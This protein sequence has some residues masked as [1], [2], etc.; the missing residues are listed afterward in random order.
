VK[1]RII[2]P[3]LFIFL[4]ISIAGAT[5]NDPVQN[6]SLYQAPLWEQNYTQGMHDGYDYA[7]GYP[8]SY[9]FQP[10]GN[11]YTYME[12]NWDLIDNP[13]ELKFYVSNLKFLVT[14]PGYLQLNQSYFNSVYISS[15]TISII[16]LNIF[17]GG[18]QVGNG[19]VYV[20]NY[21]EPYLEIHINN[22]TESD[23]TGLKSYTLITEVPIFSSGGIAI[24]DAFPDSQP[25]LFRGYYTEGVFSRNFFLS[26]N[27]YFNETQTIHHFGID[28]IN[29]SYIYN[30]NESYGYLELQSSLPV[31]Q[32]N[33]YN[34]YNN[35]T[36]D[37]VTHFNVTLVETA[38]NNLQI[39][40]F[41][42]YNYGLQEYVYTF[43]DS[44]MYISSDI[45]PP[46]NPTP[47]PIPTPKPAN[48][49]LEITRQ[50]KTFNTG[51]F[52]YINYS[53][54]K[55]P[56]LLY[57]YQT[58]YGESEIE[59]WSFYN[60]QK[61]NYLL[62][63]LNPT[64]FTGNYYSIVAIY[65]NSRITYD[66]FS[67][68]IPF[69]PNQTFIPQIIFPNEYY[70]GK[71]FSVRAKTNQTSQ[72]YLHIYSENSIIP[73]YRYPFNSYE[74]TFNILISDSYSPQFFTFKIVNESDWSEL[75]STD[76]FIS[77]YNVPKIHNISA[78]KACFYPNE[79]IK[80]FGD[81]VRYEVYNS[82]GILI[83]NG[84]YHSEFEITLPTGDY[85]VKSYDSDD[86]ES[87][88]VVHVG[89]GE[90][91]VPTLSPSSQPSFNVVNLIGNK[92]FWGLFIL[93]LFGAV[94]A[95][96]GEKAFM[97]A[98][99]AAVM[100]NYLMGLFPQWTVILIAIVTIAILAMK[101]SEMIVKE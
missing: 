61:Y 75:Y 3:L 91:A 49:T 46:P 78:S 64:Q 32:V 26:T 1:T 68:G 5:I 58:D 25:V 71:E 81:G 9:L 67:I 13:D 2:F 17:S 10:S 89:T 57:L 79:S 14:N 11:Y 98:I 36:Y 34:D 73:I 83:M 99:A 60:T 76:K 7:I 54:D 92:Y 97:G 27:E 87:S 19:W 22:I 23:R 44:N 56:W 88:V 69:N 12:I 86:I 45:T 63:Y 93:I 90:C 4:T 31:Y 72:T 8:L 82:N 96:S 84:S 38:N 35:L 33:I 55:T 41:Y 51:E 40:I 74:Q 100:V 43:T 101:T 95:K 47:A 62:K 24:Y 59:H 39:D 48:I 29:V 52:V 20:Y 94:G 6:F 37:N 53:S 50:N 15:D 77:Y 30:K 28:T 65:N 21:S 70:I 16:K 85:V 80:I 42:Y 18:T 66:N